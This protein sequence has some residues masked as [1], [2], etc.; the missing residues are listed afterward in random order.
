MAIKK[1]T[2]IH[3]KYYGQYRVR[4]E[5]VVNGVKVSVPVHYAST[6][7]KA[8]LLQSRLVLEANKGLD[9]RDA[10]MTL[11]SAFS[12]FVKRQNNLDRWS[13]MTYKSWKFTSQMVQQ[14]C[15]TLK[16]KDCNEDAIRR[17]VHAYIDD[18]KRHA[19][20]TPS[21]TV[22]KMLMQLRCFF[23]TL[24]GT[25]IKASQM[26][27]PENRPLQKMFRIDE[28]E[29]KPEKYI[30][31]DKEVQ[32]FIIQVKKE[33]AESDVKNIVSRL[34]AWIQLE[35]G[36]RTQELQALRFNDLNEEKHCFI[37]HDSFSQAKG[38]H[39]D[40]NHHLKARK[41]GETRETLTVSD[42][43][44]NEIK[45][46]KR[47]QQRY[48][49]E[50]GVENKEDLVLLCLTDKRLAILNRPI[51]QRSMNSMVQALAKRIGVETD[52]HISCYT[53]R[54]TAAS[55]IARICPNYPLDAARLGHSLSVFMN[56]Y[57][58]ADQ[59]NETSLSEGWL[60]AL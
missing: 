12:N 28:Q 15:G 7:R 18:P 14:Y 40:F 34:A 51:T 49:K 33:L 26:P 27:I 46:F 20:V 2:N 32:D 22:A 4:V 55:K 43:L 35:T 9:Y 52:L 24:V 56:T 41:P 30:L 37:L 54:R 17:F 29:A 48:L 11:A 25:S 59:S 45:A 47:A 60:A 3:S 58:Q 13:P 10:N 5:P 8:E 39:G 53:L 16:I 50:W 57:V 44:I 21:G 36:M 19:K 1:I 38:K 31:T 42:A 6:K 23:K